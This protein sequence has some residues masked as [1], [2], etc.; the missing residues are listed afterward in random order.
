[1]EFA[2]NLDILLQSGCNRSSKNKK[3]RKILKYHQT[4]FLAGKI[5]Q[6]YIIFSGT[7]KWNLS[8]DYNQIITNHPWSENSFGVTIVMLLELRDFPK[9]NIKSKNVRVVSM[10]AT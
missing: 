2:N 4:Y 10:G 6:H 8:Y 1:M 5:F 3:S 9:K 7:L